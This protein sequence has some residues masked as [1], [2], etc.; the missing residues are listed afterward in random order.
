VINV[1][2]THG[3]LAVFVD[4]A[5]TPVVQN[6]IDTTTGKGWNSAQLGLNYTSGMATSELYFDDAEVALY[7]DLSPT[8][9]LGCD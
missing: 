3:N 6:E 8:I 5:T 4:G 9:H 2:Q 1:D 7:R